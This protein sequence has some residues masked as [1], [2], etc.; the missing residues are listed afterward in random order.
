MTLN[1]PERLNS[2]ILPLV[3][4]L[5]FIIAIHIENYCDFLHLLLWLT[6]I[7]CVRPAHVVLVLSGFRFEYCVIGRVACRNV[8]SSSQNTSMCALFSRAVSQRVGPCIDRY[9]HLYSAYKSKESLGASVAKEVCFQR[10][11][12]RIKGKS[13][14]QQ[15]GWK[16]PRNSCRDVSTYELRTLSRKRTLSWLRILS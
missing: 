5:Y 6:L 8:D 10:S 16:M 9:I 3:N 1:D 13:R 11:S 14:L 4:K 2:P 15:S 12:E 7:D